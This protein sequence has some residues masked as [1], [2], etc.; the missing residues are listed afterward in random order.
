MILENFN[1]RYAVYRS[2]TYFQ[3]GLPEPTDDSPKPS[4][5]I[6]HE[7]VCKL[8]PWGDICPPRI[9]LARQLHPS[10]LAFRRRIPPFQFMC[11]SMLTYC[12]A[13]ASL[14][15]TWGKSFVFLNRLTDF[16]ISSD[17]KFARG[18]HWFSLSQC[19]RD[20]LVSHVFV[21]KNLVFLIGLSFV[22][23]I[24]SFFVLRP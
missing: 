3:I 12:F 5:L 18:A 1:I 14:S 24:S 19:S 7:S 2:L 17:F 9:L 15:F 8:C 21:N 20:L 11:N 23:M 10:I 4:T 22:L 6:Q 16:A 13:N